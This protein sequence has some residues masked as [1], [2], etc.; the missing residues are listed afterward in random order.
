MK[1][2]MF[3]CHGNI[4]RSPMAELLMKKL[5]ADKKVESEFLI[6]S[7]ALSNEEIGNP[8]YY[9]TIPIY[10]RLGI[11]YTKKRAVRLK[12]S[13][14]DNFDLFIGMDN[15]NKTWLKDLF[16]GD[17]E[18]KVYMLLD[19]TKEKGE[20]SDPWWTRDFEKA[21]K[22]INRGVNALFEKLM[23]K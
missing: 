17:K 18:N 21:Y 22:D 9:A 23:K 7:S 11:D 8:V 12:K 5:V 4:C 10:E 3:V 13:D 16:N 20:V 1:K 15:A 14:Y 6:Q 19:F 2:I